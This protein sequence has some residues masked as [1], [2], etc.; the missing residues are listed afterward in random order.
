MIEVFTHYSKRTQLYANEGGAERVRFLQGGK[1]AE[2]SGDDLDI[3]SF[4][5]DYF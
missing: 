3:L 4:F 5:Y 2:I 1:K